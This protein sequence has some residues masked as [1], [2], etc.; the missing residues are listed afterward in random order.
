VDAEYEELLSA[1][2]PLDELPDMDENT[3]A[4]M[5]YTTGTTGLPKGVYFTQR[6]L[7]LHTLAVGLAV[8]AFGNFGG[9]GKNDVYMPL[10]P[11]FYV[12]A[13]GITCPPSSASSRSIRAGTSR[14]C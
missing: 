2:I 9:V 13:W 12:H 7:V 8:A 4:T 5:A 1:A 14:R 3:V 6:Q 10:T 11:M